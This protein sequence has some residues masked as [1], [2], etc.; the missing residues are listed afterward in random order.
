[1]GCDKEG[2][3]GKLIMIVYGLQ[4]SQM[5]LQNVEQNIFDIYCLHISRFY[6]G[7]L[8]ATQIRAGHFKIFLGNG[9]IILRVIA[10]DIPH[11]RTF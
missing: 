10:S 9:L 1:M 8:V 2:Q 11:L 5:E 7:A 3:G 4:N 6:S